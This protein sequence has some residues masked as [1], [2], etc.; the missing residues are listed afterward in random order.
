[1]IATG[2]NSGNVADHDNWIEN[3]RFAI[4]LQKSCEEKYG[5]FARSLYFVSKK[6]NHDL[7][8]G[9]LL[10]EMGSEANTL[11][12]VKYS[13]ELLSNALIPVLENLQSD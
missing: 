13:A 9:S 12:Q 2:C 8:P 5:K 11:E 4:R 3:F 6:Y 1:M 10:I 7:T